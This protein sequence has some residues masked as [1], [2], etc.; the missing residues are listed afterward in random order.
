MVKFDIFL[1]PLIHKEAFPLNSA[2]DFKNLIP[3][4]LRDRISN[5]TSTQIAVNRV[6]SYNLNA[7]RFLINLKGCSLSEIGGGERGSPTP[8][9]ACL[10]L[11]IPRGRR[12]NAH[13]P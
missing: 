12:A 9:A 6:Y 1:G 5:A 10:L 11:D 8:T 4:E 7:P 2:N 13:K 3:E